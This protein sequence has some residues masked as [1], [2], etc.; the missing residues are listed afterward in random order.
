MAEVRLGTHHAVSCWILEKVLDLTCKGESLSFQERDTEMGL[1]GA[2]TDSYTR[3]GHDD[4]GLHLA[5]GCR[6]YQKMKKLV[7]RKT[8]A[9]SMK[10][11][12]KGK[13]NERVKGGSNLIDF[14]QKES[15]SLQS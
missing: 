8:R 6:M 11:Y 9:E 4:K 2:C 10:S 1:N 13:G 15:G 14:T 3:K 12:F 5:S 7:H